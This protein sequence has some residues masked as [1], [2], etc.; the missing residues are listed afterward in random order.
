MLDY[1]KDNEF[2]EIIK[3]MVSNDTVLEMKNYRQHYDTSCFD[4]CLNV[5]YYSYLVCK[6]LGLDY[7]SISRAGLVHDLFLYDWRVKQ[8]NRK[9]FHAF[10]HPRIA[11]ENANK[12]FDLNDKEKDII[13]K[14]MWPLT[15]KLPKYKESYIIGFIDKYCAIKESVTAW[16]NSSSFKKAYRYAYLFLGIYLFYI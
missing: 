11:F 1:S 9:G 16:K 13:L 14:H 2:Q 10:T 15:L 6:K 7:K 3:D 5:A 8:E 4:H 12:L